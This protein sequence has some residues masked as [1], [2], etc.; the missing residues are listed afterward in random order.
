[1]HSFSYD[2]SQALLTVVQQG[3]W[4]IADFRAFEH[5]FLI[6][7]AR[8]RVKRRSYKVLADCRDYPVQPPEIGAAFGVLFEKLM[9]ENKGPYAIVAASALNKMQARRALPF[10]N[11]Q[12]FTDLDEAKSWLSGEALPN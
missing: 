7:H 3:Y 4:S 5:D 8:I 1:M 2:E 6:Q 10:P 12:I 11:I 9:G